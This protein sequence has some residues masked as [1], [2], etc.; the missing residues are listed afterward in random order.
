MMTWLDFILLKFFK[1]IEIEV[2]HYCF[3]SR[4]FDITVVDTGS[5]YQFLVKKSAKKEGLL[6]KNVKRLR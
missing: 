2:G 1:K 5:D 6:K 4:L 3:A